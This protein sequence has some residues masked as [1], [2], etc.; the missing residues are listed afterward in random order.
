MDCVNEVVNV[1]YAES[2]GETQQGIRSVIHVILNRAKVLGKRPC[3]VVKQRG[4]FARGIHRPSDPKWQ[5]IKR[6]VLSPGSDITRGATYFH[7]LTVRP[8]WSY[9]MKVTLK[10]NKHI[11]YRA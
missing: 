5:E 4:Q 10:L 8:A 7:N 6:L 3:F 9:K 2:R 11:F 1:A